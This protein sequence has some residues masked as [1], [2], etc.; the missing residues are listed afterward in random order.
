MVPRFV[1]LYATHPKSC[2]VGLGP[3]LLFCSCLT[4]PTVVGVLALMAAQT[5]SALET[6]RGGG[7]RCKGPV[8]SKMERAVW[9]LGRTVSR[10]AMVLSHSSPRWKFLTHWSTPV[11]CCCFKGWKWRFFQTPASPGV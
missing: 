7:A 9:R 6:S 2:W 4:K 1:H 10:E 5:E 11:S 3:I 8:H